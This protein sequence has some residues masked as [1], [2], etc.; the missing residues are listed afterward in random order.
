M[1]NWQNI[2]RKFNEFS[3]IHVFNNTNG[4][5][6]TCEVIP[7]KLTDNTRRSKFNSIQ[8]EFPLS[9]SLSTEVNNFSH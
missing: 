3:A 5:N 7:I 8:L 4:I 9:I 6:L 2:R 1:V